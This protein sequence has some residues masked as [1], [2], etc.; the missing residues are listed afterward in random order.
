MRYFTLPVKNDKYAKWKQMRV[1][2][3][4]HQDNRF[5]QEMTLISN[6]T[7]PPKGKEQEGMH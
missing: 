2:R 4:E 3:R 7:G 5:F 6:L 1:Q